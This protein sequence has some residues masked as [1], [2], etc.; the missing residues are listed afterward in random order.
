MLFLLIIARWLNSNLTTLSGIVSSLEM[1]QVSVPLP[2]TFASGATYNTNLK[3]IIDADLPTGK[4]CIG[5]IGWDSS[6]ASILVSQ[7]RYVNNSYS[8]HCINTSSSAYTN[9][10]AQVHYLCI[11]S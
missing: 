7:L 3:T 1:R 5:I 4:K 10:S 9:K 2:A 6:G 8:F 11:K